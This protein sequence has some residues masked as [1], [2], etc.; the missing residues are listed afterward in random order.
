MNGDWKT[1]LKN[2]FYGTSKSE[3]ESNRPAI[4]GLVF[5]RDYYKTDDGDDNDDDLRSFQTDYPASSIFA[6]NRSHWVLLDNDCS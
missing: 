4:N 2:D 3:S 5:G 1:D 6:G